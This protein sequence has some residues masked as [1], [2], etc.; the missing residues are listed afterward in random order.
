MDR[1]QLEQLFGEV[2]LSALCIKRRD[3]LNM[4][5]SLLKALLTHAPLA[6]AAVELAGRVPE[7]GLTLSSEELDLVSA[8]IRHTHDRAARAGRSAD[9]GDLLMIVVSLAEASG[10][11][12]SELPQPARLEVAL[13]HLRGQEH[14][15]GG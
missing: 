9:A 13:R 8:V 7:D 3:G 11:E 5:Q 12:L 1:N 4:F 15:T 6:A 10:F 14:Q 2:V